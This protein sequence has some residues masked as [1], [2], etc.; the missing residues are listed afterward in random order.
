MTEDKDPKKTNDEE[1]APGSGNEQETSQQRSEAEKDPWTQDGS[2]E[3]AGADTPSAQVAS[4]N[5]PTSSDEKKPTNKKSG[6][7]PDLS[8]DDWERELINRLAFSAIN[9]Q[10]R[11][12]RWNIFFKGAFLVYLLGILFL[13]IPKETG[14]IHLG[15]HT[16]MVE[17]TGPIADN[18]FANANTIINGL[19]AA[20][21]DKNTKGVILRVNSPGGSPVHAGYIN[22]E[23][24]R[25]KEK[26]PNTPFYVVIADMCAS[27]A[28]YIAAA[29]D[30]IYADKA[31]IVGSIGVLMDGFGFVDTLDK[32]GVDRR[33]M[34]AGEN[35]AFLDPFS[36]LK[37]KH[38]DHMQ[39]LL[40]NVHEQFINVV[41]QGRGNRLV[42]DPKLFSGLVWTGE[43]SV[44]LGLI[45]GL[46]NLSYVARDV[47]GHEKIVDFTPRPD[48]FERFAE[49]IG[50][51]I[52]NTFSSMIA[53]PNLK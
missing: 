32:L 19:R 21:K 15:P 48:Y 5:K 1:R 8:K 13:Y 4:D 31:S 47:I 11:T 50:V 28:Y 42:D 3:T 25:L 12:R 40:N 51:S 53:A 26:Y 35:K 37:E 30:E 52:A 43:R 20:F 24:V 10:R 38:Q 23:I 16:A 39:G 49:R 2:S 9:E 14:D 22:D 6:N 27:A 29:A 46:G 18:A 7:K 34:T 45:D 33:L 41:K 44:E 36:P 17:L